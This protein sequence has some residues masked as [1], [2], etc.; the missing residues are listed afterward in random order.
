MRRM[1][2]KTN[3][4]IFKEHNFK[5][6]NNK[7]RLPLAWMTPQEAKAIVYLDKGLLF[8]CARKSKLSKLHVNSIKLM[9]LFW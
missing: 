7:S 1:N 3:I 5:S 6:K 2:I 4:Y 8:S 9:T